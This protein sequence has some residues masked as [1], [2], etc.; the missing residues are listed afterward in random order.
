MNSV[1]DF[2]ETADIETSS[3]DYARRFSGAVGAWFLKIQEDATVRMLSDYPGASVLDVGGGHGQ[4]AGAL[5]QRGHRV[6]VVGSA[7]VCKARLETF[8]S[9]GRCDFKAGNL[10]ALPYPDRAF[11][12]V[13][14]YRLLA[15][16][17]QWTQLIR[18]LTR[19]A[20]EAVVIDYPSIRSFN[21]FAAQFFGLKKHI[22]GNTR[23]F[24]CFK[25]A[26]LVQICET[27]G[28]ARV[29]RYPEFFLPMVIHRLVQRPVLS[30][31][32]E[33]LFRYLGITSLLGSPVIVK[34]RRKHSS[35]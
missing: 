24:A 12:V 27:L 35:Q 13:I 20:R 10:L 14:S 28:F 34:F 19:V 18:E 9:E 1:S 23:P 32:A 29:D 26:D 33:A 17:I 11:D 31:A 25:E 4:L 5:I 3:E 21:W 22:E 6:T 7:D 2:I 15:H 16:V 30:A 8:I